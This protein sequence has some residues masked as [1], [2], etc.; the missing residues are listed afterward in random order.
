[1]YVMRMLTVHA[2]EVNS[3]RNEK[4]TYLVNQERK[5]QSNAKK[6]VPPEVTGGGC[7]GDSTVMGEPICMNDGNRDVVPDK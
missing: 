4:D 2:I 5:R 1:M 7:S 3:G 6:L